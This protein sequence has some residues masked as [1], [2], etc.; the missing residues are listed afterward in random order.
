MEK[1]NTTSASQWIIHWKNCI[2]VVLHI[3][4]LMHAIA[5]MPV[6]VRE[7]AGALP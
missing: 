7:P 2:L 4:M 6:M 1:T 5:T 3:V